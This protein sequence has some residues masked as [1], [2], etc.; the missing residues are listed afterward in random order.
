MG[1]I[2][3]EDWTICSNRGIALDT[4]E[5]KLTCSIEGIEKLFGIPGRFVN[6]K[7][8]GVFLRRPISVCQVEGDTI[9]LI[10]RIVGKGT[11]L[12]VSK[13]TG[14]KINLLFPL[15]NGFDTDLIPHKTWSKG[16]GDRK[17]VLI[18]GGVGLPPLYGLAKKLVA[19][20]KT[21][22]VIMGFATKEQ[23]FYKK[24]FESLGIAVTV[25][26]VDGS[27]GVLGTVVDAA[28]GRTWDYL[29]ACGPEPMLKGVRNLATD[30]QFSFE[31]RMGCG[32]G[33]CMGCSCRTK[34]GEKRICVDG[35]VLQ[36]EEIVW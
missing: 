28:A 29:F 31:S 5:M 4:W 9:T 14:D 11:A 1:T 3:K 15:G 36:K 26:T 2:M 12:L 35:P 18:G 13:E 7:I 25:A 33:V 16:A 19:Q 17:I 32:F 27:A 22:D 10:Y 30:G 6:L 21:P 20:G 24:E 34:Y 23:I 8:D